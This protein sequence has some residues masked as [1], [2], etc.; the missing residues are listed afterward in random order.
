MR[1]GFSLAQDDEGLNAWAAVFYLL[2]LIL[3][4]LATP[5]DRA[6]LSRFAEGGYS[7]HQFRCTNSET[8]P[9]TRLP[10][11]YFCVADLTAP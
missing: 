10:P 4:G 6:P 11:A 2:W 7:N 1:R 5:P 3:A 9:E 8:V